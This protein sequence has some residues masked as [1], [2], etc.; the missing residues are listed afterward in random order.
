VANE[1]PV[2]AQPPLWRRILHPKLR[3]AVKVVGGMIVGTLVGVGVQKALQSTGLMG[4]DVGTLIAEQQSN[5]A[6]IKGK[7]DALR[8]VSSDPAAQRALNELSAALQ[9][10]NALSQQTEQQL[11]LLA[12]EVSTN[13]ERELAEHGVSGGA[14]FWLKVGESYNLATRDQVFGLQGYGN[15]VVQ[16]SLNGAVTRLAVGGVVEFMAG[17]R[18]CKVFYKQATPRP[19]GRVGFDLDCK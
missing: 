8:K 2:P 5:F 15:G 11:R 6:E 1:Q 16:V 7:L 19:D 13:K 17:R 4:P 12:S 3:D 14:D 9:K 18:A 10:Q